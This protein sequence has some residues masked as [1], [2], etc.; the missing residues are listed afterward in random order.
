MAVDRKEVTGYTGFGPTYL[1][2]D[3]EKKV[4]GLCLSVVE[5]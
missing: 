1:R 3:Q 5:N 2:F 4:T